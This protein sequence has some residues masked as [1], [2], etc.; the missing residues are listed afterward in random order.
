[1]R[2]RGMACHAPTEQPYYF[3]NAFIFIIY[4]VDYKIALKLV[5]K[6]Y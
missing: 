4:W 1:M 3:I 5:P 6:G 2:S